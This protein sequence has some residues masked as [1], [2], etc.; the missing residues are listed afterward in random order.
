M[1]QHWSGHLALLKGAHSLFMALAT[2]SSIIVLLWLS[3]HRVAHG[4]ERR[5]SGNID[6]LLC[7]K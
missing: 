5:V 3:V 7:C 4:D 1:M 6:L 2:S